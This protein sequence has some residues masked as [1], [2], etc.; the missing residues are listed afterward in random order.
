MVK[1]LQQSLEA[2]LA[3]F[4]DDDDSNDERDDDGPTAISSK[5]ERGGSKRKG[6]KKDDG[7]STGTSDEPER[8][9]S[10]IYIG[11]LPVGFEEQEI[12]AFLNQFG[13]VR[14]CRVCR[15]KKTGRSKGYGFVSFRD[16]EVAQIVAE[17]LSGYFL[18]EK[19]LVCHVLP[20]EKVHDDLF[21]K[22]KIQTKATLQNAAREEVN[23]RRSS[24]DAMMKLTEKLIKRNAKKQRKLA[25]LGIDYD[26]PSLDEEKK[27]DADADRE[28]TVQNDDEMPPES[29]KKRKSRKKSKEARDDV[30]APE[31]SAKSKKRLKNVDKPEGSVVKSKKKSK[32][33]IQGKKA[34]GV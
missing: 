11:H 9:S 24:S 29:K 23:K 21:A 27:A 28:G 3:S 34:R 22:R 8:P 31:E 25:S 26:I 20:N 10:V 13:A 1:S 30:E 5:Q 6:R 16:V 7:K 18:L 32:A 17:T 15:S 14:E 33:K 19:R 12:T 4:N 2:K